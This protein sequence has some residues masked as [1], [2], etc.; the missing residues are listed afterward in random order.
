MHAEPELKTLPAVF[1]RLVETR[2]DHPAVVMADDT[3][4]YAEL[5]RRSAEFARALL[6]AGAGKG[7]RIALLS[8]D[9]IFWMTAFLAC[10]RIGALVSLVSTLGTARELAH[11]LRNSDTQFLISQRRFLNHDYAGKLA[12]AL[13]ELAGAGAGALRLADAPYLRA[14]WF[15]DAEGIDWAQSVDELVALANHPGAPD[16]KLLAAMEAEVAPSD[17]AVIVYTSGSTSAPKAVVH[18]QRTLA[19]HPP[20]VAKHFLLKADDRMMPTLPVFWLG[21]LVMALEVMSVGATLVYP[22]S[23]S[24]E[25]MV[26][27]IA[28]LDVNRVNSW[29]DMMAKLTESARERGVDVDNIIGLGEFREA[30]GE[31]IPQ[32]LRVNPLGMSETFA[33]HSAE[34]LNA[35]MPENKPGTSGRTV[36]NYQRRLVNPDTGEEVAV[37]EAGELQL[38]GGG[39][40]TGFYK[41]EREQ[42][43]TPDGFY[44]TGD[45]CR[46]DE[47]GYL[48]FIARLGDMIKTRSANVSRL[49]VEAAMRELPEVEI[50]VVAGIDDPEFG[51]RVVAAVV[52]K[53]GASASEESLQNALKQA[54]SSYKVPRNIVFIDEADIP[55]T[56]TGKLKLAEIG[57]M[58]AARID[59]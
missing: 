17:D 7:A 11:M 53:E 14:A 12:E 50:P 21:G 3:V 51:Q 41:R 35:R 29:G 24:L 43:F 32:Q 44:P 19:C 5:E 23:P 31:V 8:S 33:V 42:V 6:Q 38:R 55:R 13:P 30:S 52:L 34:P 46:E 47:D 15:D 57:A 22:R 28:N 58:I 45:L 25:D 4:T 39:L 40:M 1:A 2:P 37:G 20:E 48:Y 59:I 10:M 49:E 56:S 16:D 36:N 18:S 26:D 9:G 27:A 54:I